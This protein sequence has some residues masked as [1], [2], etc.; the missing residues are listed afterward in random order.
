LYSSIAVKFQ[1]KYFITKSPHSGG[2][3]FGLWHLNISLLLQPIVPLKLC[4]ITIST[5][6]SNDKGHKIRD[7][8]NGMV[9]CTG[10][11]DADAEGTKNVKGDHMLR[12]RNKCA[13]GQK[14]M[15]SSAS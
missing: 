1:T 9:A 5:A 4:T 14:S 12:E 13:A 3:A 11:D 6:I 8:E 7:N 10:D 15:S 2:V